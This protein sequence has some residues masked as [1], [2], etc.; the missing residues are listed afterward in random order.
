MSQPSPIVAATAEDVRADLTFIVPQDHK[1]SFKSAALTGGEPEVDFRTESR[2]VL[3]RD[4]R[5]VAHTLS[6]DTTGFE[7]HT[8]VT[9]VDDLYDDL[10]VDRV[11]RDEL[12][13]L[14]MDVTG[15]DRVEVFDFTRRSDS[16]R[17][18]ANPDGS[19]GPA[20]RVHVDYTVDSGPKRAR[21]ALA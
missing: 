1:P 7:L 19:R 15:A 17:G 11:Y 4:M 3:V 20:S 2:E 8:H 6:L 5:P 16:P 10:A 14:L 18:A 13:A 21:D 9:A 12:R